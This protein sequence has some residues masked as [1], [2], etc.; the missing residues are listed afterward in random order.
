[1]KKKPQ[2]PRSLK[3]I[4]KLYKSDPSQLSPA[5][6]ALLRREL[7]QRAAPKDY[8]KVKERARERNS[9][10]SRAGR[11][12][13][14]IPPI[15]NP[16]RRD[17]CE[18]DLRLFL[19]TYFGHVFFLPWSPDH[20]DLIA[21]AEQAT[22]H[23][24][25]FP[26]ALPRASGK[27]TIV[28]GTAIWAAAYGH[29]SY[30]V[31]IGSDAPS[32]EQILDSIKSELENNEVLAEDFPELCIPIVRLEG[33]A[34]RCKGQHL[35]GARTH[36]TWTKRK[37][38][39]PTV[40]GSKSSGAIIQ[41]TGITGRIRG[42][43]HKR[44]DGTSVRPDLAIIDDPQT[45]ESAASVT[46]CDTRERTMNS[47]ILGLAGPTRK[48]AGLVPCTVIRKNDLADRTLTKWHGQRVAAM[49][50]F[51][52]DKQLWQ[53]YA[54]RRAEGLRTKQG[55]AAAT[56]FYKEHRAAMDEGAEVYWP[57]RFNP[58]EISAVQNLM[59]LLLQDE[60]AFW[61]E[62]QNNPKDLTASEKELT[63]EEI[64]KKVN[65]LK[66][67]V[68]P[69][70]ASH[71]VAFI[72]V[73]G[74]LLYYL[75]LAVADN[76]TAAIVDAA[77]F[78]DQQRVYWSLRDARPT[79]A[80]VAKKDDG[81]EAQIYAGLTGLTAHILGR[82]WVV[83][84]GSTM[85]I[86]KCL[87]DAN[88]GFS[89]ETVKLFCRQSQHAAVLLPSHGRFFGAAQTPLS[90][91][92]PQPGEVIREEWRIGNRESKH[93]VRSVLYNTNHWKT[94]AAG[95]LRT[96]MGGP[97]CW[98]VWGD[99]PE[100]HRLLAEHLTSEYPVEVEARGR[101]SDEWHLRPNRENHFWDCLVGAG[102]AGSIQGARL[103]GKPEGPKQKIKLSELQKRK[104][105]AA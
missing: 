9:R 35:D 7:Q 99:K 80:D 34:N 91:Y 33:I 88:W 98:S 73:Q 22:L 97:G 48:I 101:K 23:G 68:V 11:D 52:T 86:S 84:N 92:K 45:E 63:I 60:E 49:K 77:A 5:E 4:A 15:G 29:R 62:Y 102:V 47:A 28:E 81:P 56:K 75:V 31:I 41:V 90:Q 50:S 38:V 18:R 64:T 70:Y 58:D 55:L 53:Q 74:A 20:L 12:I 16:A 3:E 105:K 13:S 39:L 100:R 66:R 79:L 82:Q 54:E 10:L 17:S 57:E 67:G 43:K 21:R 46:Q 83:E 6:L 96:A 27:T 59:N 89:T 1:M 95:R 72:D 85:K 51:P 76:F 44:V 65:G 93:N 19:E 24:G 2:K 104:Q 8:Q 71:L 78:P 30:V 25:M 32:A 94:F 14:P 69:I 26:F 42:M 87:I 103:I 61:S 36:I 37:I 40:E